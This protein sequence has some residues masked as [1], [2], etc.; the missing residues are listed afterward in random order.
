VRVKDGFPRTLPD[1]FQGMQLVVFGRYQGSGS[2]VIT[3][4]GTAGDEE[5]VYK[6]EVNFPEKELGN[7]YLP[8]LW[9]GRK[10]AYLVDSIRLSGKQDKEVI[11]EIVTLGKKY[12]IVTPYTSFLI[13]EENAGQFGHRAEEELDRGFRMAQGSGGAGKKDET[14]KSQDDS[15]NLEKAKEAPAA[16]A[17]EGEADKALAEARKRGNTSVDQIKYVGTK[18]FYLKS[19]IWTD[20]AF[21]REKMKD[22][23]RKIVFLSE[24]YLKL[25]D[26]HEGI[27][28][29]LAVGERLILVWGDQVFQIEPAADK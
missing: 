7:D 22:K 8:R 18:V 19:R 17:M 29:Y 1:L 3:L 21:D 24:E 2:T 14:K 20:G 25:V 13:T 5:K 9:A 10:V 23:L 12:G 28:K 4:K 16:D 15:R 6:Y 11:E 26:Q 27:Q